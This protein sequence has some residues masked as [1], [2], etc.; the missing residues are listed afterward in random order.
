MSQ[1]RH[2]LCAGDVLTMLVSSVF[3]II[4]L[5]CLSIHIYG[6]L[7]SDDRRCV[8]EFAQI[9]SVCSIVFD[10]MWV[11]CP[12]L[13]P[14]TIQTLLILFFSS[15]VFFDH[16]HV[17]KNAID[18]IVTGLWWLSCSAC[19]PIIANSHGNGTNDG[20]GVYQHQY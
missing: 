1:F 9:H 15:F 6:Y 7:Q 16:Q 10:F 11:F 13:A 8:N 20:S 14:F 12:M 5:F 17:C 4:P 3:S 19:L 18:R 2:R